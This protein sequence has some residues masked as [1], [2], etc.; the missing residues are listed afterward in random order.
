MA[1]IDSVA[2]HQGW[3]LRGVPLYIPALF[4]MMNMCSQ[5]AQ[6]GTEFKGESNHNPFITIENY[7]SFSFKF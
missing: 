5:F 7:F 2:A 4:C 1:V 6:E 3:P